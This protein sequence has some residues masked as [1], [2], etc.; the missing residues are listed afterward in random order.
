M[1][2]IKRLLNDEY[3]EA[4]SNEGFLGRSQEIYHRNNS[5]YE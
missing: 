1:T 4:L 2:S 3:D 5:P